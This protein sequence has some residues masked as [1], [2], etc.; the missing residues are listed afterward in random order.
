MICR[1]CGSPRLREHCK[2]FDNA[3]LRYLR[4]VACGSLNL[5]KSYDQ[6]VAVYNNPQ[7][8]EDHTL[9]LGSVEE[10]S[11]SYES[12]LAWMS[13]ACPQRGRVLDIGCLGGGFMVCAERHGWEAWG[14]DVSA[15]TRDVAVANSTLSP[16]RFLIAPELSAAAIGEQFT[17][18]HCSDV[19]E[20]VESPRQLLSEMRSLIADGGRLFVQTPTPEG[21]DGAIWN[22]DIHLCIMPEEALRWLLYD[23]G[24]EVEEQYALTWLRKWDRPN[25]GSVDSGGQCYLCR[26]R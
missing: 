24:F 20:H 26:V 17:V 5:T 21:G 22:Q 7:C 6:C 13:D 1:C 8:I 3:G 10:S 18:V 14:F 23:S 9:H 15:T 12:H 19:I 11:K 4:C 2:C 25:H 16:D